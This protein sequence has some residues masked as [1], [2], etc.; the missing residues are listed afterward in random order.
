MFA[1]MRNITI[2][3]LGPLIGS[4]PTIASYRL[5]TISSPFGAMAW[6]DGSLYRM[7]LLRSARKMSGIAS[8]H[9]HTQHL[10]FHGDVVLVHK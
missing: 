6:R 4:L 10:V 1:L 8:F 7:L 3:L 9:P 5:P 2:F